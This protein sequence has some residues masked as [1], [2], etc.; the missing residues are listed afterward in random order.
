M[1]AR[2][3]DGTVDL[4]SARGAGAVTVQGRAVAPAAE[5]ETPQRGQGLAPRVAR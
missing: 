1:L 2:R 4:G 3:V 5:H